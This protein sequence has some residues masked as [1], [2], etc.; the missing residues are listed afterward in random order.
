M[1]QLSKVTIINYLYDKYKQ[2]PIMPE[3][4][5]KRVPASQVIA[6]MA[7]DHGYEPKEIVERHREES[8]KAN[9]R[10]IPTMLYTRRNC[11]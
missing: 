10:L 8:Q 11:E 5:E 9:H 1:T 6:T 7:K 4:R 3:I 2:E